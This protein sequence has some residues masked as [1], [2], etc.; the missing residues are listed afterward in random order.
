VIYPDFT[1]IRPARGRAD[2]LRDKLRLGREEAGAADLGDRE[3]T[4][5][6]T[7]ALGRAIRQEAQDIHRKYLKPLHTTDFARFGDVRAKVKRQ[8]DAARRTIDHTGERTRAM[9]RKVRAVE[10]LPDDEDDQTTIQRPRGRRA[11]KGC[12]TP[13]TGKNVRR[14]PRSS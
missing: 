11:P 13:H 3:A 14:S 6:A 5:R 12:R 4:Q 9:E 1:G 2:P 8:L 7:E 10:Q